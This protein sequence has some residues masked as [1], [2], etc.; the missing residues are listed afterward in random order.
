MCNRIPEMPLDPP[1]PK[2]PVYTT[3]DFCG[4]P[5]YSEDKYVCIEGHRYCMECI[6]DCTMTAPEVYE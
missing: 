5:I 4:E 1:E 3:C 6:S 2:T